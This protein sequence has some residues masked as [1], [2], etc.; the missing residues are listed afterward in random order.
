MIG[1]SVRNLLD[2]QKAWMADR[3]GETRSD[4]GRQS[5]PTYVESWGRAYRSS[6][7][8]SKQE[9]FDRRYIG[10]HV[11]CRTY[12]QLCSFK[13]LVTVKKDLSIFD[14]AILFVSC[15]RGQ[16]QTV[17]LVLSSIILLLPQLSISYS[18]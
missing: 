13:S 16:R 11:W 3:V 6:K 10:Y 2:K 17:F 18:V 9:T 5:T 4:R 14:P 7:G 15:L 12:W 8:I 1:A